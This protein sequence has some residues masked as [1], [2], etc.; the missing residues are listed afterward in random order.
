MLSLQQ[1]LVG[2][3]KD[4]QIKDPYLNRL[5]FEIEVKKRKDFHIDEEVIIF[6]SR[7]LQSDP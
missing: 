6:R 2:K 4:L 1:T 3:I 5:K 7:A